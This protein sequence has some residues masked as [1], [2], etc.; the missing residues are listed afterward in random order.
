MGWGRRVLST[1][2]QDKAGCVS[3]AQVRFPGE[4]TS[5]NQSWAL[6]GR[7]RGEGGWTWSCGLCRKG[8]SSKLMGSV[9]GST[10]PISAHVVLFSL[11]QTRILPATWD[12]THQ[13]PKFSCSSGGCLLLDFGRKSP[14]IPVQ[15]AEP[16]PPFCPSLFLRTLNT[17]QTWC[18][19]EHKLWKHQPLWPQHPCMLKQCGRIYRIKCCLWS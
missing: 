9:A 10:S 11:P 7:H 6:E 4:D 17:F 19:T 5:Q 8:V 2:G 16:S 14:N 18:F 13:A 15:R 1:K 12:L 3:R